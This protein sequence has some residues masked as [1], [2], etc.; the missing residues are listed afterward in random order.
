[1]RHD[2]LHS[3]EPFSSARVWRGCNSKLAEHECTGPE[4]MANSGHESMKELVRYTKGADQAK[5]ARNAM[6]RTVT[7]NRR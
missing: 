1:M 7:A 3:G 4:I 5:L 6:V 2:S